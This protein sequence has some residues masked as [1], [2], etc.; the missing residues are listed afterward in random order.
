MKHYVALIKRYWIDTNKIHY[1]FLW[2]TENSIPSN[3]HSKI[4]DEREAYFS[5]IQWKE[6]EYEWQHGIE[7]KKHFI[8]KANIQKKI[9]KL[10]ICSIKTIQGDSGVLLEPNLLEG[11][12]MPGSS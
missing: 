2:Y 8:V 1:L 7:K 4:Q 9:W 5:S 11:R 12:E 10:K 6:S 3:G